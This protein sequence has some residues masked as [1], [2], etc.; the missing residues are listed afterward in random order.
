MNDTKRTPLTKDAY[1]RLQNELEHLEGE[2][3][4]N[5]IEAIASARSHGDLSENAEYHA[6]RDQQGMQEARARQIRQMLE[7]A[8]IV[9][10]D[11]SGVVKPG[12]LVTIRYEGDDDAETYFLGLREEKSAAYDVLTPESPLGQALLGRTAGDVVAAEVPTGELQV[13]VVEVRAP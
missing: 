11:D 1:E 10:A 5:I 8:E 9:E 12:M 6:A 3:R 13:E 4:E 2:G 7:N